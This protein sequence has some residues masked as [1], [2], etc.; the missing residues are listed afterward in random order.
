MEKKGYKKIFQRKSF[1]AYMVANII[2][3]FGDSLDSIAFTWIVYAITGNAFWSAL[4]FGVNRLPTIFL[5]P[6]VGV[7]ADRFNKKWIVIITDCIRGF[8]VLFIALG[9]LGGWLT[10]WHLLAATLLISTAEAFRMPASSSMIPQ[11]IDAEDYEYGISLNQGLGST[12][13]LIGLASSGLIIGLF[14]VVSAVFIDMITFFLCAFIFLFIKLKPLEKNN[15]KEESYFTQL[16]DGFQFVK[17]NSIIVYFLILALFLNA[18]TSPFNSLQAPLVSEILKSGEIMLSVVGAS[19]AFGGIFGSL[20]FPF[21]NKYFSGPQFVK[22]AGIALVLMYLGPVVIGQYVEVEWL[23]YIL[24][25]VIGTIIG[26]EIGLI[27]TYLSVMVMQK[28]KREYLGRVQSITH[29]VSVAATPVTAFITSI[30]VLYLSTQYIFIISGCIAI[31]AVFT[32]CSKKFF[33]HMISDEDLKS[34]ES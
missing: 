19:F 27:N 28:V 33:H 3:R 6:F 16:K 10:E 7:L 22:Q 25:G 24:T 14:G 20:M 13:E 5:Q 1:V 12:V 21:A 2:N 18:I 32:I 8:T 34:L 17:G 11:L 9:V 4:I 23:K 15:Q 29:A 30:A 31:V 26:F